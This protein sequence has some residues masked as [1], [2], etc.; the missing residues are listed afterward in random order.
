MKRPTDQDW[1]DFYT[2]N[3]FLDDATWDLAEVVVH[4]T[5]AVLDEIR[6]DV[7]SLDDSEA[8]EYFEIFQF[9][10][11]FLSQKKIK[12]AADVVSAAPGV[13]IV[14]ASPE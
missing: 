10:Y 7:E 3:N 8:M 2:P 13:R 14:V 12:A 11:E 1:R 6:N 4:N 9:N 5:E